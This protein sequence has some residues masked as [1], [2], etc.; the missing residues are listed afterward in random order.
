LLVI[1]G[2]NSQS[3]GEVRHYRIGLLSGSPIFDSAFD[4]F[5]E[6][7]ASQGFVEGKNVTYILQSA[8][9]NVDEMRSI[10]QK[11]VEDKV[12][13][14]FTTTNAAAEVARGITEESG[15]PV[16]FSFVI[17][18]VEAGIVAN[19]RSP[20]G[21]IT[22]VRNPLED[23]VGR[24]I[25]LMLQMSPETRTIWAP[26]DSTYPTVATVFNR[27]HELAPELGITL[28]ET[29]IASPQDVVDA[30][31]GFDTENLPFDA[32]FIFPDL[33]VQ[34]AVAWDAILKLAKENNLPILANTPGQVRQGALFSY[35]IDNVATGQQCARIAV[36]ILNGAKPSE[37][38]VE[39]AELL[40]MLNLE[41][42]EQLGLEV[43]TAVIATAQTVIRKTE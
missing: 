35:L 3:A 33:K 25:D 43:P 24:R 8:D 6:E 23:F 2:C 41:N 38:P 39:T 7:L 37:L 31:E 36:Q 5:K 21:N 28:V 16:V 15:I 40:L 13:L 9:G 19:L 32:I 42:A 20:G 14:I 22:G 30:I 18:P 1:S 4:G 27:L 17:A 11:F 26:Y 29:V 10:A 12:D 34:Q